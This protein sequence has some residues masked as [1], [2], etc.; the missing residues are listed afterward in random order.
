METSCLFAEGSLHA[1]PRASVSHC[2]RKTG[3]PQAAFH[4]Q[5]Q[6]G[7]FLNNRGPHSKTF[8]YNAIFSGRGTFNWAGHVQGTGQRSSRSR[9]GVI[10]AVLLDSAAGPRR[11]STLQSSNGRDFGNGLNVLY[12]TPQRGAASPLGASLAP[13]RVGVNFAITTDGADTVS[14]CLLT[15]E[16]LQNVRRQPG[17]PRQ[18]NA[19]LDLFLCN[20]APDWVIVADAQNCIMGVI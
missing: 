9:G 8:S 2:Q 10:K 11:Y 7:K 14:L 18:C 12:D 16:D 17:L 15:E 5:S 13:G 4:S 20:T 19:I 6:L 1:L 3:H